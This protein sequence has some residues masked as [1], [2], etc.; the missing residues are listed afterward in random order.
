M[1]SMGRDKAVNSSKTYSNRSFKTSEDSN[2]M[3]PTCRTSQEDLKI[4]ISQL[5]EKA[6]QSFMQV[7]YS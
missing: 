3:C 2:F 4:Q 7:L 6:H 1:L 5:K